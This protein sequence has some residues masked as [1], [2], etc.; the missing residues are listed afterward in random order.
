LKHVYEK[1]GMFLFLV[2]LAMLGATIVAKEAPIYLQYVAA[3]GL[4]AG[5]FFA[6]KGGSVMGGVELIGSISNIMSY[7]RIMAVGLAGAIFASATNELVVS[8]GNIVGGIVIGVLL[9]GLN[10]L[11]AIFSPTI[12]A[13]RLNFLEFFQKFYETGNQEYRPFHKTGGA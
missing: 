3:L 2:S 7:I 4:F 9:H 11:I 6:I 5:A 12:H 8:N 1:G 13:F 10:I